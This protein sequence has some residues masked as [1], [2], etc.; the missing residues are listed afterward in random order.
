MLN[1]LEWSDF[2]RYLAHPT[3][4]VVLIK[5]WKTFAP[6]ASGVR[7]RRLVAGTRP[8]TTLPP[9]MHSYTYAICCASSA[10]LFETDG[11]L[12]TLLKR[13]E[14]PCYIQKPRLSPYH[15]PSIDG[16]HPFVA[17]ADALSGQVVG[18]AV[19]PMR[20]AMIAKLEFITDGMLSLQIFFSISDYNHLPQLIDTVGH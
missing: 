15:L 3:N 1:D 10:R 8:A 18:G 4:P 5:A 20:W 19:L 2:T 16:H 6:A 13:P 14:R 9:M 11:P 7:H 17:L 12:K